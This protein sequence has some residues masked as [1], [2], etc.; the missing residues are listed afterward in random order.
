MSV[1]ADLNAPT[2][3]ARLDALR[4]HLEAN[5]DS[6][7]DVPFSDEVNNHVH[8]AYSFSPYSPTAAAWMARSAG[9]RAVGSVDHDSI[10]AATETLQACRMIGIGGTVGCEIRVNFTGTAVEGRSINNPDS[11]NLAYIV[12]HGVPTTRIDEV[13]GFLAPVR[14]RRNERNAR[15]TRAMSDLLEAVGAPPVSFSDVTS[16]SLAAEG[17][18]ITERHILYAASRSLMEWMQPGLALRRFVE[19]Q[20]SGPLPDRL[21]T[22]LD[23]A[24]NPHYVYD[25]LG[26]LKSSFLPVFFEQPSEDECIPVAEAV[27]FA[28]SIEAISAYA[29]LGDIADSPTGDKKAATFEDAYLDELF[30]E[31]ERLG[32]R[33][34]TYMPPRNT[35]AQLRRVQELCRTHGLMEIS[36]VD[37][38]SSRQ[39]FTCEEILRP[40]F[41]HL[42]D[43]TWALIAHEK[44]AT[45]SPQYS[46]FS[47]ESPVSGDL[48]SRIETYAR[49]GRAID[50]HHPEAVPSAAAGIASFG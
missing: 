17:G 22:F 50:P 19:E 49:I 10:A 32:F 30:D 34:V 15:Q 37:I 18:G 40:E 12:F 4:G 29:Y 14:R 9:L 39:A 38:N 45:V 1:P 46:L 41:R 16:A 33:A 48:F 27:A 13:D 5:T 21:R 26:A 31:L 36:G 6:I 2:R 28:N 47:A 25:L 35:L 24:H 23:D 3:A 8:T 43:A 44:L 7:R 20:L 42:I 11:P